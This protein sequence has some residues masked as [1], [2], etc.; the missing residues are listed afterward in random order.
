[1]PPRLAGNT[2]PCQRPANDIARGRETGYD[3]PSVAFR[4]PGMS[5]KIEDY[6]ED[7]VAWRR[8]IHKHPE[9]AYEE[10]RTADIVAD[11]L[12]S[13]GIEIDR[14]L[15]TTGVVGTLKA[16]TGN[17]AI[18]LRAD[19]D[20]LPIRELNDFEHRSTHDGVM[21]ACGHDG[22]TTMLLGAARYLAVT[23]DFDGIV[24]FIFQPA[25]EAAGG[26][27]VMIEDGL[28]HKFPV[29][30]V[31]G[32]H[33]MPGLP[34]GEFHMRPGALMAGFL[35]FVIEVTGVGAHAG[36]PHL[37]RDS[38][39]IASHIV[40]ALQTIVA[41]TV[42]PLQ[43]ALVSVTRI[44]GGDA[45]NV[46]PEKVEIGGSCRGFSDEML[47]LLRGRISEIAEGVARTH[48]AAAK[49]DFVEYYPPLINGEDGVRAAA[50]AATDV[51]GADKV[52]TDATPV[53]GSEDFAYML[54]E[55][56]GS[57]IFI[58]NGPGD[59]GCLLHNPH[60]DFNDD[61]LV[62]GARYWAR[63]VERELPV[64]SG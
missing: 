53:M 43:S 49:V 47:D 2:A 37:G 3:A 10:V 30:A 20:A 25:E 28:F 62:T 48:G 38:I 39:V 63:L 7:M 36:F 16:G 58:G 17:R 18:G 24:H 35:S 54:K 41:R 34:L 59:G 12:Q 11:K 45:F 4:V 52:H 50:E 27:R 8:D 32:M 61:I 6:L 19:M 29:E 44:H 33:N 5:E 56:P 23:R 22:H 14:G 26:A 13:W 42:D 15:A 9:L 31:Y 21:H 55:R 64:K 40:T 57:Y 60:Y 51:V 46:L 1:M